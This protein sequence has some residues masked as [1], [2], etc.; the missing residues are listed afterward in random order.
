MHF[1]GEIQKVRRRHVV[2]STIKPV[3]V[4]DDGDEVI[5]LF[6]RLKVALVLPDQ[7][8]LF[9]Y[10]ETNCHIIVEPSVRNKACYYV[11]EG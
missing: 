2:L 5:G 11:S 4:P 10:G 9:L 1:H 6:F 3:F 8:M 7:G